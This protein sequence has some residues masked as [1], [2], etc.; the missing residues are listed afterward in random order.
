MVDLTPYKAR[1]ETARQSAVIDYDD[2]RAAFLAELSAADFKAPRHLEVGRLVRID[3]PQDKRGKKSGW[4]IYNEFENSEG[5]V[6]GVGTYGSWRGN[7]DK[8]S[9]SS[10]SMNGMTMAEKME[11]NRQI[12]AARVKRDEE[13]K[14]IHAEAAKKAYDIWQN[15]E[16]AEDNHGYLIRKQVG[17]SDGVRLSRGNLVV[18]ICLDNE[19]VSLQFILPEKDEDGKDKYFLTGGRYRGCYFVIEGESTDAIFIAEGYATGKTINM[20]TDCT[21][22]IAFTAGNLYEVAAQV[23]AKNP[24]SKI[25]ICGDDD[26]KT[27]GNAGRTK[28]TQ[29]ADGL[30]LGLVFPS[31]DAGTAFVDFNDLQV[32][33]GGLDMV[34]ACLFSKPK[35]Y[36]KKI[37]ANDS[38]DLYA[39]C[40]IMGE[41][42]NYY[43]STSGIRQNGFAVQAAIAC[44]SIL[45]ARNFSTNLNNRASLFMMNIGKSATGKEHP[46]K[47]LEL[48][49]EATGNSHLI[50]GDGYTSGAAVISALQDR[51]RHV[52]VID[53]Y[54]KYLQAANNK[55]GNSHLA[56]ANTRLMETIGRLDGVIRN[57][58]YASVGQT[59][60]RKKELANQIVV[61][62]AITLLGMA[63]PDDMFSTI[64]VRS[65]KDGFLN[66]FIICVSDVERQKRVHKENLDVPQTIIEWH[67]KIRTRRGDL[68]ETA[69][70]APV[71]V[72][73]VFTSEALALSD[74]F[75]QFCIDTANSLEN[76][77]MA[78]ITGRSN[79]MAMRLSLIVALS[80]DPMSES[81]CAD[82]MR[83]S[84][85][86][87]KYN[88]RVLVERMKLSVA[89]SEHE[90]F[91]KELLKAMR[92]RGDAGITW[93]Q[94]QKQTP[95]SKH[96]TKELKEMLQALLDAELAV[97]E[98]YQS[99]GKGRPTQLWKA[100]E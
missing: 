43:H 47:V 22:Y 56:E 25:V 82:D 15:A 74:E 2:P 32:D 65:I 77:G 89:S 91:K 10:R 1:I 12:E 90:G 38:G 14:I 97:N 81:I 33:G 27:A 49:L 40:G 75:Q 95:F 29:A 59:K 41:I 28:A 4:Y 71:P 23:K 19:I 39:P 88:L 80:R 17:T 67:D 35:A 72:T 92:E 78:E 66:R 93:S 70:E 37:I 26:Y 64:D 6:L 85:E 24:D 54:A 58:A 34:K 69:T 84:I 96:K 50:S 62:P 61:A 16:E 11:Y 51:P 3:D 60:D 30:S 53:E 21:V 36:K 46:K 98:P 45:L 48:V 87:V 5:R 18:P 76:Y 7:P 63:T 100:I 20:A 79:E 52:T 44:C 55:Y 9:W 68:I 8:I 42:V 57:K 94:M 31:N 86:W 99:G 13:Q 83:W 73:L